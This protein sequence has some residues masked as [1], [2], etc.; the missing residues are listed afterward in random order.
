MLDQQR[1]GGRISIVRRTF[2]IIVGDDGRHYF[3]MP[4]DVM[5]PSKFGLLGEDK[6]VQFA[7]YSHTRTVDGKQV[8]GMRATN[9]VV[10]AVDPSTTVTHAKV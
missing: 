7:G 10:V 4:T 6:P 5:P 9:I 2:G 1:I 8:Q 3:F